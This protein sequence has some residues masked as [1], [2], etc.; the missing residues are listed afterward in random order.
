MSIVLHTRKNYKQLGHA[1]LA[2]L[3]QAR[4]Q[5]SLAREVFVSQEAVHGWLT[6]KRRPTPGNLGHIAAIFNINP[7]HLASLAA[8]DDD[9]T[10]LEKVLTAYDQWHARQA[11]GKDRSNDDGWNETNDGDRDSASA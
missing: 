2:A 3:G 1:L 4:S 8:Y 10:A 7:W 6:G 5:Q 9:P 11:I